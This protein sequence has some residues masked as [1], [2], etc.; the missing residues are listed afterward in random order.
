M[1][2]SMTT[3]VIAVFANPALAHVDAQLHTHGIEPVS[4][5]A[6]TGLVLVAAAAATWRSSSR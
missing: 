1:K 4:L 2:T 6:A 5:F 3:L